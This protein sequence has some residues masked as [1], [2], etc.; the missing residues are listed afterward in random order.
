MRY[1]IRDGNIA[2]ATL[3]SPVLAATFVY[4]GN[5]ES[6][7]IYVLQLNQ[8]TGELTL[9]EKVPIPGVIKSGGSTPMTVSP[10]RRFL[11]VTPMRSAMRPKKRHIFIALSSSRFS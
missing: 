4:V 11:F 5:A 9:F 1:T 6:N 10:D 3:G 8:Q 7:D 2:G